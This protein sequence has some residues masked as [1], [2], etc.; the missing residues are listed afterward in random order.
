LKYLQGDFSRP[1]ISLD[2]SLGTFRREN[3]LRRKHVQDK[4]S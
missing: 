4:E 3:V 2:S 1:G